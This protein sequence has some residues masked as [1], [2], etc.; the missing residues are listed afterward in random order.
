LQTGFST[1]T[2]HN[3]RSNK[4]RDRGQAL[5][6]TAIVLPVILLVA[7]SIFEIGRAYQ[8]SQVLTNAAREGA[9]IA[10]MPGTKVADV[11][12]VVKSYLQ[13]GQL[14]GYASATVTVDQNMVIPIGTGNASGSL[15]TVSYPFSFMVLNPV[16]KLV[17]KNSTTG[18][19]GILLSGK[20][21]MRN[22]VQ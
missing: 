11:Q 17:V 15:V 2:Q 14:G 21:E 16:A 20:A 12:S 4:R 9:R 7:V 5:I 22:E 10:V 6:E 19:S 1:M 18:G 8:T 13:N 3:V